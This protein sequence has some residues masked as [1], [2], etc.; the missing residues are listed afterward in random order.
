M[1]SSVWQP[2]RSRLSPLY[3]KFELKPFEFQILRHAGNP[4]SHG[5]K[6]LK[7]VVVVCF[8]LFCIQGGHWE[9]ILAINNWNPQDFYTLARIGKSSV[10]AIPAEA[11]ALSISVRDS[12][13]AGLDSKFVALSDWQFLSTRCEEAWPGSW[14]TSGFCNNRVH[15]CALKLTHSDILDLQSAVYGWQAMHSKRS[16][17]RAIRRCNLHESKDLETSGWLHYWPNR[18]CPGSLEDLR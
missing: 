8:K 4:L 10:W 13:W 17:F 7:S 6:A 1:N 3:S 9:G 5:L 12:F 2:V 18:P 11:I 15:G 14:M 16:R